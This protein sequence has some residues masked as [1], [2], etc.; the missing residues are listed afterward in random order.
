MFTPEGDQW[1]LMKDP[2]RTP[3][4]RVRSPLRSPSETTYEV[5]TGA[6]GVQVSMSRDWSQSANVI[7]GAGQDLA[8]TSFSG[9]QV[10]TDGETT[11]YEPFSA[12]PQVHPNT[13]ANPRLIPTMARKESRLTF[14]QGVDELAARDIAVTQIRRFADPGYTGSITL[15]TDP[16]LRGEPANRLLVQAG[17]QIVLRGFRGTDVLFHIS[18]VE[19]SPQEGTAVLSVDTKFRDALTVAEV[20][21]RTR[22]ALDP[23][24]LLQAGKQSVT[25]QDL[26]KPWSYSGGSGVIPS[27]S[28]LDATPL[29]KQ[30]PLT[31]KFPWT[32]HTTRF[33]PKKYPQYYIKVSRKG[34]KAADRWQDNGYSATLKKS[35]GV[36]IKAAQNGTIRLIQIAAFDRDGHPIKIRFHFGIYMNSGILST[37]MPMVPSGLKGIPYAAADRYPLFPGAFE[38]FKPNGEEQ[39]NPNE[40]LPEGADMVV[41]WGTSHDPAGYSPGLFSTGAA[42]TGQL[43]DETAWTF[44]TSSVPGFDKYSV[45]NNAKNKSAG[46]LYCM[47]FQDDVQEAYFL[48]RAFVNPPGSQ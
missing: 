11:F 32:A 30:M 2:G 15:D 47:I 9:A 5:F 41:A 23:V 24:Y 44:D 38:Q 4:L 22:D 43:I 14:P 1:T 34:P 13:A 19:V 6:P 37:D 48:G 31:T 8:G 39:N 46:M 28:S 12:L 36:P 27:G 16:L 40:L 33:P 21:A 18:Q 3:V 45:A 7:Y 29:F 42:K 17:S 20:K 35:R 10:S 25:V 26:L